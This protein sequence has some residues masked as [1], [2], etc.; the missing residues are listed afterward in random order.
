MSGMDPEVYRDKVYGCWLGKKAGGTLGAPLEGQRGPHRV[1]W[2]PELREGANDDLE[3]QLIWLEALERYGPALDSR[4]LAERWLDCVFYNW[5]EYGMAKTNLRLG[6]P[7]P[8]SGAY[9]NWFKDCT[10]APIRSEIWAC[11]APGRPELAARLAYEDAIVD[12]AGGEGAYGEVFLAALE[13][14]AFVSGD[15]ERLINVGLEAIPEECR[16]AKAVRDTLR[17]YGESGS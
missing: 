2:Y 16:V 12:H 8:L 14:E 1:S 11:V 10:G 13:S 9:N 5:D 4:I 3:L 7:P 6:L 15:V 17:W